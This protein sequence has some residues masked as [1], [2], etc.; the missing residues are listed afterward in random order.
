M[1]GSHWLVVVH[2]SQ[3]RGVELA[4]GMWSAGRVMNPVLQGRGGCGASQGV[5]PFAAESWSPSRVTCQASHTAATQKIMLVMLRLGNWAYHKSPR[6]QDSHSGF[7]QIPT[8]LSW[9]R[10]WDLDLF[11]M[12]MRHLHDTDCQSVLEEGCTSANSSCSFLMRSFSDQ[13]NPVLFAISSWSTVRWR[14]A[15]AWLFWHVVSNEA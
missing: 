2:G 9:N 10:A 13:S 3:I 1:F 7:P 4:L 8:P 12:M 5:W 14:S 15:S 11:R 6:L